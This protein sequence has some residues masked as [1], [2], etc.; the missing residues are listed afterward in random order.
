MRSDVS[1]SLQCC[2]AVLLVSFSGCVQVCFLSLAMLGLEH[3]GGLSHS[4][5]WDAA[6][7]VAPISARTYAMPC[8]MPNPEGTSRAVRDITAAPSRS[9][10]PTDSCPCMPCLGALC[11]GRGGS[12]G[13]ESSDAW[14]PT[15]ESERRA[16]L[17]RPPAIAMLADSLEPAQIF[18]LQ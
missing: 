6:L 2:V 7:S 15:S 1:G 9:L 16:P 14:L 13:T 11:S 12:A 8:D 5:S 10:T 18:L 3:L 17:H 4:A